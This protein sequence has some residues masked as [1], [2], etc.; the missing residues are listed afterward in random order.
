LDEEYPEEYVAPVDDY[1]EPSEENDLLN[2]V[3]NFRGDKPPT[4]SNWASRGRGGFRGGRGGFTQRNTFTQR[5]S[6]TTQPGKSDLRHPGEDKQS[7]LFSADD[8]FSANGTEGTNFIPRKG[9]DGK[10][11]VCWNCQ[12]TGHIARHCRA[13]PC[14]TVKNASAWGD[15]AHL[16]GLFMVDGIPGDSEK[17]CPRGE[18]WTDNMLAMCNTARQFVHGIAETTRTGDPN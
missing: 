16:A 14:D 3:G 6:S 15:L 5:N 17:D 9:P 4:R 12:K 13:G 8:L 1:V 11:I 2:A 18:A 10:E 7:S